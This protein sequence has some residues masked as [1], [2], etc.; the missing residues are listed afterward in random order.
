[1]FGNLPRRVEKIKPQFSLLGISSSSFFTYWYNSNNSPKT[2]FQRI[3]FFFFSEIKFLFGIEHCIS[4]ILF[5]SLRLIMFQ[6][7]PYSL[8]PNHIAC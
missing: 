7:S 5:M 8:K 2:E 6:A 3:F 1:M 4:L